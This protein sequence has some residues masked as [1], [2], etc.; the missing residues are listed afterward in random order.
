LIETAKMYNPN[1]KVD[2]LAIPPRVDDGNVCCKW[3]LSMRDESDPE[4]VPVEL[5]PKPGVEA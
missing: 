1:M 3:Q 4:F 2:I 5:G